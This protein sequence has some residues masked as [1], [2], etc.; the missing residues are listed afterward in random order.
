[1]L[2]FLALLI[3]CAAM[4]F[5]SFTL[6]YS[7]LGPIVHAQTPGVEKCDDLRRA[8][9]TKTEMHNCECARSHS[10]AEVPP[11][12]GGKCK[13]YCRDQNCKCAMPPECS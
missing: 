3:I 7:L 1:M 6:G 5:A 12:P 11:S 9:N 10:C 4:G 2:R 13:T 8:P